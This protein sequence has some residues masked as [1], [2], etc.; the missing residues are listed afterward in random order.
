MDSRFLRLSGV[1]AAVLVATVSAPLD[2]AQFSVNANPVVESGG[3]S[4]GGSCGTVVLSHSSS[5]AITS[6]NSVSCN[7]GGLHTDNFYY[8][9][10]DLASFGQPGF[11]VCSVEIGVEVAV[12]NGG[13]QPIEI[14]LYQGAPGNFPAALG[15][16]IGNSVTTVSDQS[17]TVATFPVSGDAPDSS[18]LVVE[19]FTPSGQ[20]SG[21]SFFIGS[22]A[23]AESGPSYLAAPDC[24]IT[25]P[26]PTAG[27]GVPNMH[28]VMN[29]NGDP[30]AGE[31]GE[32][33][34]AIPTL[35]GL[36]YAALIG[37]IVLASVMILRRRRA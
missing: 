14:R 35:N 2:A 27:I 30:L 36:G 20:A 19:I 32:S 34:L 21:N 37:L 11:S 26:T 29:V 4:E 5:Q 9:V 7:A 22:N 1:A 12:G 25:V 16:L 17:L 8:R 3:G 13:T 24:G 31:P 33:I 6:L 18:E 23:A 28:I 10:F 15:T